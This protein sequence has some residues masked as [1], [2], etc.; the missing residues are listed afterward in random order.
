[1]ILK[2]LNNS[3]LVRSY[4][5]FCQFFRE[6]ENVS[7]LIDEI[8]KAIKISLFLFVR[9]LFHMNVTNAYLES[10]RISLLF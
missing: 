6:I 1:M 7:L 8:L 4:L 2:L 3:R 9:N 5:C 10:L